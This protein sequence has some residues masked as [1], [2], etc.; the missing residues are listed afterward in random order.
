MKEIKVQDHSHLVRDPLTNAIINTNKSG[1]D[2]YIARREVKKSETQKVKD[3]ETE[4]SSMK[5]DL[6]EIKSLLRRLSNES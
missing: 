6:N 4:L 1:Y 3:L 5:D 2:E